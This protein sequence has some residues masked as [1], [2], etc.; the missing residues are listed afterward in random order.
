MTIIPASISHLLYSQAISQ[1][2]SNKY[3]TRYQHSSADKM[4]VALADIQ[5]DDT[6]ANVRPNTFLLPDF[7][8]GD[9]VPNS[10]NNSHQIAT[11][12]FGQN[13]G[14]P[15]WR[16]A[17]NRALGHLISGNDGDDGFG[18]EK[19]NG[20]GK[21]NG[22]RNDNGHIKLDKKADLQYTI[23]VGL[24]FGTPRDNIWMVLN[25][26][27]NTVLDKLNNGQFES[28]ALNVRNGS[29]VLRC[30]ANF[31]SETVGMAGEDDDMEYVLTSLEQWLYT[32]LDMQVQG[33]ETSIPWMAGPWSMN[34]LP[35]RL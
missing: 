2:T 8:D 25:R 23:F 1:P 10:N 31:Q 9:G 3:Q 17:A 30:D 14:Y 5:M 24:P 13:N 18:D 22:G 29:L 6:P 12:G 32:L 34:W 19:P 20:D 7:P 11:N 21:G 4:P 15:R 28:T 33:A 27:R 35:F 26:A 16:T